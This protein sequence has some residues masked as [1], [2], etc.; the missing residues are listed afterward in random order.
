[1]YAYQKFVIGDVILAGLAIADMASKHGDK[2]V[3]KFL[4]Y[5]TGFFAG[6]FSPETIA[7]ILPAVVTGL[8]TLFEQHGAKVG[9]VIRHVEFPFYKM[10][11][12]SKARMDAIREKYSITYSFSMDDA[13]KPTHE[14]LVVATTNCG[15]SMAVM[16]NYC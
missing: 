7:N 5:G 15:D 10:E 14:G 3:F 13:L 9:G 12:E 1:M 4:K 8:E 6:Q 11:T 16:G 2:V